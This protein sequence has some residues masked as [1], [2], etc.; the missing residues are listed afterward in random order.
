MKQ[1]GIVR[2]RPETSP[3]PHLVCYLC[4]CRTLTYATASLL[5]VLLLLFLEKPEGHLDQFYPKPNSWGPTARTLV[6]CWVNFG[7]TWICRASEFVLATWGM[8]GD[9]TAL[10]RLKNISNSNLWC[11]RGGRCHV[12]WKKTKVPKLFCTYGWDFFL[13]RIHSGQ[14][15]E[16]AVIPR[17]L[18]RPPSALLLCNPCVVRGSPTKGTKS[19]VAAT[20]LASRGPKR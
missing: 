6:L 5:L 8:F 7:S 19:E 3:L 13:D 20:T 15:Y 11:S 12:L 16:Q 14:R 9:L 10:S 2:R 18:L 17:F 1:Y 4:Y